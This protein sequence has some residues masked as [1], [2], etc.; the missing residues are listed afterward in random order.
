[1][2]LAG[3]ACHREIQEMREHLAG[4]RCIS[5]GRVGTQDK[6]MNILFTRC[7]YHSLIAFYSADTRILSTFTMKVAP[8]SG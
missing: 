1:M 6:I 2:H 3:M 4:R 5:H 8:G 7:L